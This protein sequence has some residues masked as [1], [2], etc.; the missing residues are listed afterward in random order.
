MFISFQKFL[1]QFFFCLAAQQLYHGPSA[2]GTRKKTFDKTLCP[3]Y[4]RSLYIQ[5]L[6]VY[7]VLQPAAQSPGLAPP[8][9]R[10]RATAAQTAATRRRATA[11][12]TSATAPTDA[13]PPS[14]QWPLGS[15]PWRW[16]RCSNCGCPNHGVFF[17]KTCTN[18][19]TVIN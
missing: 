13:E 11:T 18:I 19:D 14:Q 17:I 3:T 12:Q 8:A 4:C 5:S 1:L 7:S 10:V 2:C 16:P 15:S 6:E 9:A